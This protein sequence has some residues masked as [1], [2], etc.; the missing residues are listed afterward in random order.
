[1]QGK[2]MRSTADQNATCTKCHTEQAGPFVYEH[3][4][5]KTEGCTSCHTPHGSKNAR[6]L[7]MSNVNTQCR[8]C[9][10]TTHASALPAGSAHDQMSTEAACT[11]CHTHIHGSNADRNFLK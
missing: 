10:S 5:V 2:M 7:N 11:S 3:P 6:L 1:M 4:V 8:E 9:H